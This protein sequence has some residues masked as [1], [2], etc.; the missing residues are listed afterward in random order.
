M[1]RGWCW[2]GKNMKAAMLRERKK[3]NH[4]EKEMRSLLEREWESSLFVSDACRDL[5][6]PDWSWW[7]CQRSILIPILSVKKTRRIFSL[8]FILKPFYF[9]F[10]SIFSFFLHRIVI[11][12]RH[13]SAYQPADDGKTGLFKGVQHS[14]SYIS[15]YKYIDVEEGWC[16][17]VKKSGNKRQCKECFLWPAE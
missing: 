12:R 1:D 9:H 15:L 7:D 11:R 13:A 8:R 5:C 17:R 4:K 3:E 6:L 2:L 16:F 14:I 10:S